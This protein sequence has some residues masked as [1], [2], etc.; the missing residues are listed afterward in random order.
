M[1]APPSFCFLRANGSAHTVDVLS[2]NAAEE[3]GYRFAEDFLNEVG[4]ERLEA[5]KEAVFD[6]NFLLFAFGNN[7]AV[8]VDD[9]CLN[10][11][12]F[13]RVFDCVALAR[14]DI[15]TVYE[16]VN[17]RAV[18]KVACVNREGLLLFVARCAFKFA[19][20]NFNGNRFVSRGVGRVF[21]CRGYFGS[22]LQCFRFLLSL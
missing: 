11:V 1:A 8:F 3:V 22:V 19:E 7:I 13:G 10:G 2:A 5:V 16:P 9:L 4:E 14:A 17:L 15:L 6:C 18:G 20:V 21:G 12:V